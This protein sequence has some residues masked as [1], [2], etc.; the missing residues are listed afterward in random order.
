MDILLTPNALSKALR[1]TGVWDGQSLNKALKEETKVVKKRGRPP[2]VKSE[3]KDTGSVKNKAAE[4]KETPVQKRAAKGDKSRVQVTNEDLVKDMI[5]YLKPTLARHKGCDLVSVYPGAGAWTMA[6]HDAVQPRSHLLLEPDESTYQPFLQPLL[7]QEN[8]RLVPRSGIIW[9]DL[10]AVLTPEYLPNQVEIDRNN[11]PDGPPRNDTLLVSMNLAMFPKKRFASFQSISRM[12]LFQLVQTIRTSTLYQKYGLVRMLIWIPDDEKLGVLPRV[13]SA[14]RRSAIEGELSTEYIA[15]VCG[16]DVAAEDEQSIA[17]KG[18]VQE[19]RNHDR[20]AQMDL[21]SARRCKLKMQEQGLVTPPGRLTTVMKGLDAWLAEHPSAAKKPISMWAV[22]GAV[23][24]RGVATE[25]E[26]SALQALHEKMH[27]SAEDPNYLRLKAL[28]QYYLN[29][30]SA[31]K[32]AIEFI[33]EQDAVVNAYKT[34][35][36]AR[37]TDPAS[38]AAAELLAAAQQLEADF[39][40]SAASLPKY[41]KEYALTARDAVHVL[42]RQPRELGPVMLWDRRPYEPLPCTAADFFPNVP[43]TLL[44]I[45]P[46]APHPLLRSMGPGT[47]NAGDIFDMILGVMTDSMAN[48]VDKQV[49]ALWPG[50]AEG[51]LAQC[52][53]L[54]DPAR[55]G[56]PLTGAGAITNRCLNSEQLIEILDEFMKWP[57]RPSHAEMVGRLGNEEFND[58]DSEVSI[59]GNA[60]WQAP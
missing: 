6:L 18:T 35:A 56:M 45:Q 29:I 49:S 23:G 20:W 44:D 40:A 15:E 9:E 28:E 39:N 8:V 27:L 3:D 47:D 43:C 32:H 59:K 12:V 50:A 30:A 38:A 4:P 57:F 60:S 17:K 10:D 48:T 25:A 58:D 7:D 46:K 52:K 42:M 1:D 19:G 36:L 31:V 55:G 34:A 14:R 2:K 24:G 22:R 13:L 54:T 53:T 51:F 5:D 21:E 37:E 26:Y 33:K 11:L 16:R 41:R